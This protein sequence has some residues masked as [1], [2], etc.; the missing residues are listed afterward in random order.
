MA[1]ELS[2]GARCGLPQCQANA[3]I[4]RV[5]NVN[6]A[7][8]TVRA[9]G[10]VRHGVA[11]LPSLYMIPAMKILT[12]L[13][14]VPLLAAFAVLPAQDQDQKPAP[15]S[16]GKITDSKATKADAAIVAIDKFI[17]QAEVN[18]K[19]KG[20][21]QSLKKPPKLTF[22]ADAEYYW[23]IETAVGAMK[24]RY[25]ADTAPMHVSS[26]IYL[27]RL[28]FYDNLNF[29]RIIPGFM[30]QGGCPAGS[31]R[32]NPGYFM[33]GEFKGGRIHNKA[34]IL[35]TANT[36]RPNSEGSQFFLTFGPTRSLDGKYTI[37]GEVVEGQ[38]T[39]KALAKLGSRANNGMLANGPKIVRTWIEVVAKPK[40][41]AQDSDQ[42]DAGQKDGD[43]K[44]DAKKGA[45]KKVKIRELSE[46]KG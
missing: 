4:C 2:C 35:S 18:T 6:S 38:A 21:R 7:V 24:V 15:N 28:G 23:H 10:S 14:C 19:K 11:K 32:G 33:A 30:A 9:Q 43:Q 37:W 45:V 20:W 13:V 27:S 17:A 22:S 1:R 36:G 16:Q 25:F 42:Q 40:K 41:P 29:H 31:G 34:G 3:V 12:T 26:G 5:A 46:G 8:L 39:L 44:G